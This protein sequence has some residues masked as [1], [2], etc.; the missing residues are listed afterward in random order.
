MGVGPAKISEI[1]PTK[2]AYIDSRGVDQFVDLKE[3]ARTCSVLEGTGAWPPPED[4]N[5]AAY[6]AA[7]PEFYKRDVKYGLVGMRGAVDEPPWF[8][9]FDRRRTLF[10]F[11]DRDT[12]YNELITPMARHGWQSWDG[13]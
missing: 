7:H 6:A 1:T 11:E 8:Q 13:S 12:I 9:F 3:S 4:L 5:W 10:E 2:I